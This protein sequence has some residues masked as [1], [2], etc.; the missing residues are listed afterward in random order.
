MDIWLD[1]SNIQTIQKAVKSG[2][3]SGVTTNPAIVSDSKREPEDLFEDLLHFQEGPI[4]VQVTA[5]DTAGMV[6]QGQNFYSFSNRIIVKVPMTKN[7]LEAI[8]LLSRQGIP[9]MATAIFYP[10]KALLAAQAGAHYVTPYISLIEQ[11]GDD[12]WTVLRTILN[13]YQN[14]RIKTKVLGVSLK[15]TD[16]VIQCAKTGIYGITVK[17]SLFESLI[18]DQPAFTMAMDLI[19]DSL[20]ARE[21]TSCVDCH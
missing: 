16:Q 13:I 5:E 12:P 3:L 7:G 17:D 4:A 15:T 9:T 14:Y 19:D 20:E 1:T 21:L 11:R 10:H 18:A 8:H 6:Q 2:I